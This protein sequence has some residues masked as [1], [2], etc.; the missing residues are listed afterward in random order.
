MDKQKIY[1]TIQDKS[2]LK[3]ILSS[4]SG[5]RSSDKKTINDLLFELERAEVMDEELIDDN[6]IRMNSTVLLRDMRTNEKFMYKLVYPNEANISEKKISILAPIGTA[7]LG[8]KV[9]DIIEWDVP[10]GKRKLR[11]KGV[12]TPQLQT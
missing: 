12:L 2:R 11:V 8:F 7:L 5:Y 3:K 10:A 6:V 1:V 9:G 4:T